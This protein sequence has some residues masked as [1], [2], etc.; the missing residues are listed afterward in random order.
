MAYWILKTN[1]YN[2]AK[3]F[4]CDY[5]N[6]IEKLPTT[7]KE[8][9]K[10]EGDSVSSYRCQYGSQCLCLEDSSVWLLGK[11]TNTWIK[12]NNGVSGGLSYFSQ[13]PDTLSEGMT[14]IGE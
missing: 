9:E 2:G 14:W 12:Q 4:Q 10:Q 13:E 8:G 6:D 5:I 11:D 1:N 7:T 3:Y